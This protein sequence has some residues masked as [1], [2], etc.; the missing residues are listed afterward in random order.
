[1]HSD[2]IYDIERLLKS[3]LPGEEAHSILM[4]VDRPY[5]SVIRK[6]SAD[7]RH[8]AVAIVL[9]EVESELE[10][11]LIRRPEYNGTHSRQIAFPGGKRD[12][13]DP[14]LEFTARRE[15]MEE[16]G[17]P[18]ESLRL[19]GSLTDIYI[20][21]SK[22]VVSPFVFHLEELPPLIPD[23]REV[24]GIIQFKIRQ[25]LSDDVIQ[26]MPMKLGDGLTQK[27]VPYFNIEEEI[28]W[29]ATGMMLAEFRAVL[30]QI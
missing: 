22:F 20:P 2:K 10:S 28:V 23:E 8:S 12:D 16:V 3:A 9:Y 29:G 6:S 21:V 4:P 13:T 1:M 24:D 30:Q 17:I 26:R 25:L 15:C 18:P 19:I 27:S 14:D 5:S 11:I 7:F